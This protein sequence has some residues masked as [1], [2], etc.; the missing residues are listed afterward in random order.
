MVYNHEIFVILS[1]KFLTN[2]SENIGVKIA[3]NPSQIFIF[4]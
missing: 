4:N 3:L 2:K 1:A